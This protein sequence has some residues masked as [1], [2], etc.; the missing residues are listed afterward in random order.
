MTLLILLIV[1]LALIFIGVP[2]ILCMG[3]IGLSRHVVAARRQSGA[4]SAAHVRQAR[5]LRAA[6]AALFRARRLADVAW[7]L[8]PAPRALCAHAGRPFPRRAVPCLDRRQ[9]DLR[10]RLRLID[11]RRLGHQLGDDPD[12]EAGGLQAWVCRGADRL[13]RHHRRHHPA[14]HGHG[15]LRLDGAG[16]DRRPV[17]RRHRSRRADRPIPDDRGQDPLASRGL[18]RTARD[19]GKVRSVRGLARCDRGVAGAA[20][21]DRH[22]RRNPE[23]HVHRHRSR[24]GGLL[25]RLPGEQIRLQADQV[26][27][28]AALRLTP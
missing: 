16:L 24:R 7:R 21:A 14:Q 3:V 19:H 1:L 13:R 23:R 15:R 26:P 11:R 17:S 4:V 8:E 22:H 6:G 28:P 5:Y 2:I 27:R 18:S 9:H 10:R 25:L 12:H 20:R